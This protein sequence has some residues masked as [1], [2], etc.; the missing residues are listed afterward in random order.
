MATILTHKNRVLGGQS[1]L[2]YPSTKPIP[3]FT[4]NPEWLTMPTL[5]NGDE[6]IH[7]LVEVYENSPNYINFSVNGAFTVNWGDGNTIN[8]TAGTEVNYIIQWSGTSASTLTSYGYRQAMVT[9]TPQS[10]S[11]LTVFNLQKIIRTTPNNGMQSGI[12]DIKMAAF[13]LSQLWLYGTAPHKYEIFEFVGSHKLVSNA[14]LGYGLLY[15]F[16]QLPKLKKVIAPKV[17]SAITNTEYMFNGCTS[18]VDVTLTSTSG[19]TKMNNMFA[20]CS[21]LTTLPSALDTYN[22][23]NASNMFNGAGIRRFG[24]YDLTKVTNANSMFNG[25]IDLEI[26]D[27]MSLP[28][29][30]TTDSLFSTCSKL[31]QLPNINIP[32]STTTSF[33]FNGCS[34]LVRLPNGI[35]TG[36]ALLDIKQMFYQCYKL[37]EAPLFNTSK[38]TSFYYTFGVSG[39]YS[40]PLYNTSSGTNLQGMFLQCTNLSTIPAFNFSAATSMNL[41]FSSS[42]I[43]EITLDTTINAQDM[44]NI[45][46]SCS[47]LT[48]INSIVTSAVTSSR[49]HFNGCPLLSSMPTLNVSN[50]TSLAS[51]FNGCTNLTGITLT[52]TGN[53]T[54]LNGTFQN[55]TSLKYLS[56]NDTGKVADWT[57]AFSATAFEVA[58]VLNTSG[59]TTTYTMFY[60]CTSLK[61]VPPLN[62]AKATE[63][64]YMFYGCTNLID[65][66]GLTTLS[67]TT[68]AQLFN[69]CSSLREIPTINMS[70]ITSNSS[71]LGSNQML[72]KSGISGLTRAH[73]YNSANLTQAAIVN[74]FNNLGTASGAQNI[75]V[76]LNPGSTGLTASD[77]LIAT[78][79]GW[80]V[81][82]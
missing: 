9:I 10:P 60:N 47:K 31:Y 82:Y 54:S 48:K 69:G 59:A 29:A 57:Y 23:T 73:S 72:G 67:A 49:L 14:A 46:S 34:N 56:M 21:S 15:L 12:L 19:V 68:A 76:A 44:T 51:M 3:T 66:E 61:S 43:R 30:T 81:T 77:R 11:G 6:K 28:L 42:G 37:T 26:V 65:L 22:V 75:N 16:Y 1:Q 62:V 78:N 13:N 38:V 63:I 45:L 5:V 39:I 53:V 2:G 8:Y 71:M 70:N 32:V 27:S 35:N 7:M 50:F 74:I 4:R 40:V 52:N 58:P 79:K 80:T 41:A 25:C 24:T 20:G 17:L 33:M 18:L 64:S 55:C 36:N